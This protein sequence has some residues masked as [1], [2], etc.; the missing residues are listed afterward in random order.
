MPGDREDNSAYI[1]PFV[2]WRFSRRPAVH[3]NLMFPLPP[4]ILY[5][6]GVAAAGLLL[7]FV[8][9][10]RGEYQRA[11][12]SISAL[13]ARCLPLRKRRA[14]A[15]RILISQEQLT[16]AEARRAVKSVRDSDG[17]AACPA[18]IAKLAMRIWRGER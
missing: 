5:L 14:I 15:A 1:F 16:P 9:G 11:V 17:A 18:E 10:A 13:R 2:E 8:H 12:R 3:R 6:T 4:E 7:L